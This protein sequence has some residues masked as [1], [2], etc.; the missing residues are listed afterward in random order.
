MELHRIC[1]ITFI[2]H[3]WGCIAPK[4][5]CGTEKETITRFYHVPVPPYTDTNPTRLRVPRVMCRAWHLSCVAHAELSKPAEIF[6]FCPW[7]QFVALMKGEKLTW[8][9]RWA[10][11]YAI[12]PFLSRMQTS[13]GRP[14][15]LQWPVG[16]DT[17]IGVTMCSVR[18][19]LGAPHLV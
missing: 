17:C 12:L 3:F 15:F 7:H 14:M 2:E 19:F 10:Q 16:L 1:I 13:R 4:T 8:V 11:S 5:A 9:C 18:V 6:W